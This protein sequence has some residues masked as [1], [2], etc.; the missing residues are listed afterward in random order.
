M[1]PREGQA[2]AEPGTRVLNQLG[3]A[4]AARQEPRPPGPRIDLP[5]C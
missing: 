4:T 5:P 1:T 3:D 2:P